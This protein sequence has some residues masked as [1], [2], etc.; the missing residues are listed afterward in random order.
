MCVTPVLMLCKASPCVCV[1]QV[2][3]GQLLK[4]Q[5]Q[6]LRD[7]EAVVARRES[8]VTR[9]EAQARS[10][11][12]HPTHTDLQHTLQGLRRNIAHTHKVGRT[13]PRTLIVHGDSP[14]VHTMQ[15][16]TAFWLILNHNNYQI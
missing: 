15:C 8:I 13:S 6:L 10:D 3:Y 9:S 12:K 14:G 7:M 1:F 11:R 4:Q 16:W 5:E 2:R